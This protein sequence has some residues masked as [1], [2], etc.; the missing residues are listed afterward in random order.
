VQFQNRKARKIRMNHLC[1]PDLF[2]ANPFRYQTIPACSADPNIHGHY[3]TGKRTLHLPDVQVEACRL[4]ALKRAAVPALE[5]GMG[6]VI[7]IG[8]QSIDQASA[9]PAQANHERFFCKIQDA[10]NGDLIDP[11]RSL[12]K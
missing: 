8:R 4:H 11:C 12:S 10:I 2:P 1:F 7:Y 5:M 6:R 3:L 9:Q